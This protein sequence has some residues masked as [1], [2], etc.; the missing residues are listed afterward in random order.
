M[1]NTAALK[2]TRATGT[3]EE[4]HKGEETQHESRRMESGHDILDNNAVNVLM[5]VTMSVGAMG[6][7][8]YAWKV[9]IWEAFV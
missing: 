2:G 3:S 8:S 9:S 5:A 7:A 4:A 6:V 1:A